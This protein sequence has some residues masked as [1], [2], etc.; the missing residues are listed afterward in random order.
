M[1][2][3]MYVQVRYFAN[4]GFYVLLDNQFNFDTC[5]LNIRHACR[6]SCHLAA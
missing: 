2:F 6:R 5:A 4:N 3:H 1:L